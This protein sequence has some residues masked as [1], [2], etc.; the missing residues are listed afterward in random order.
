MQVGQHR[1]PILEIAACQLVGDERMHQNESLGQAVGQPWLAL[2][3]VLNPDGG[4]GEHHQ[5]ERRRGM[6]AILGWVP[7]SAASLRA[8]SRAMSA[9]RPARTSAVFS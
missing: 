7:P 2:A 6:S 9:S 8:A 5:A 1:G 3:E 4:V